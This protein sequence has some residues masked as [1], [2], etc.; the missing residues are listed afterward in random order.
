MDG[1]RDQDASDPVDVSDSVRDI[2][3]EHGVETYT[4]RGH[5]CVAHTDFALCA[6]AYP[7][8]SANDTH[9]LQLDIIVR[10]SRL[11]T[12][13]VESFGGQGVGFSGA[14][15]DALRKFCL[16]SLHVLLASLVREDLDRGQV[17]WEVWGSG[18]RMWRVCIGPTLVQKTQQTDLDL[19]PLLDALRDAL[20]LD[21][22]PGFHWLRVYCMWNAG[23]CVGLEALLDNEPWAPGEHIVKAH[24]WP[25]VDHMYSVRL[26]LIAVPFDVAP[27]Q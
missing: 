10:S 8:P 12:E 1:V 19:A 22:N 27:E 15:G 23:E 11:E 20:V 5:V 13:L 2:L 14:L 25:L 4:Y 9:L 21:E 26:F 6:Y 18:D 17:D 16:S 7:R 24:A 3:A